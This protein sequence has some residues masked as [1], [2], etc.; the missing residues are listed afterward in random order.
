MLI[1]VLLKVLVISDIK[2]DL[3][4]T[5]SRGHKDWRNVRLLNSL[6]SLLKGPKKR[7]GGGGLHFNF[8]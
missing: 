5:R 7:I 8:V 6:L 4:Y 3:G 2:R 1:F